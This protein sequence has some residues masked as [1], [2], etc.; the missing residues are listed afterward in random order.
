MFWQKQ[1]YNMQEPFSHPCLEEIIGLQWF[2]KTGKADIQAS[3]A[4]VKEKRVVDPVLN[5][6][7]CAV[8]SILPYH[9]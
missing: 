9:V 4:M 5:L 3:Q 6:T 8:G 1:I 2:S 7:V